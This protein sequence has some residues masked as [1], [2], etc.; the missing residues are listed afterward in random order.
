MAVRTT[1]EL[2]STLNSDL[3]T[4]VPYSGELSR[5]KT[6]AKAKFEDMASFGMAKV[7]NLRKFSLS[8]VFPHLLS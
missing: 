4:Y 3:I 6:F 1:S 5:E 8:K 2:C 7:S